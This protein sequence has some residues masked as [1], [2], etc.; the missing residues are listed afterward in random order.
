M[1]FCVEEWLCDVVTDIAGKCIVVALALTLIER[2]LLEERPAFWCSA[3]RRAC[4][5]TTLIKMIIRAVLGVLPAATAFA[6]DENERRKAL[7]AY[8]MQAVAYLLWDNIGRGSRIECKYIDA[9]C[10]SNT[11]SDRLLGESEGKTV[12]AHTIHVFTGSNVNPAGDLG[13]RSLVIKLDTDRHDPENRDFRHPDPIGWT[14]ANRAR[15]IKSFYT[16]LLGNPALK[17]QR[18]APMKTRFKTFQRLV[19]S[20][21]EHA[22]SLMGKKIDFAELFSRSEAGDEASNELASFLNT[23]FSWQAEAAQSGKATFRASEVAEYINREDNP[24]ADEPGRTEKGRAIR[25]FLFPTAKFTEQ[26]SAKSVG[27][28]LNAHDGNPVS[29]G[30]DTLALKATL[31]AKTKIYDYKVVRNEGK[32]AMHP[33]HESAGRGGV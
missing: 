31:D 6:D 15:L 26:L 33:P 25:E 18:D 1:Q 7:L 16:I 21:V 13:S 19:G 23:L 5:K 10:T 4:G 29:F 27:K 12:A 8:L 20:A 11:Y 3:G 2:T 17:L 30:D 24:L 28:A 22:A 14:D 32:S 9:S